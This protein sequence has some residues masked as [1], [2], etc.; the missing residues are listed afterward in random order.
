MHKHFGER[1]DKNQLCD[2]LISNVLKFQVFN[3]ET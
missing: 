3:C 2:E 1:V